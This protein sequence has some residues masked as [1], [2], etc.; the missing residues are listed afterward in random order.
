MNILY[1]W[2]FILILLSIKKKEKTE[3]VKG[4]SIKR[5]VECKNL[6]L[7]APDY[8]LNSLMVEPCKCG[9]CFSI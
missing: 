3:V 8:S 4:K 1:G 2:S 5:G 6:G 9:F 7:K